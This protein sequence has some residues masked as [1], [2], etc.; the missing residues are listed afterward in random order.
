[1]TKYPRIAL[2]AVALAAGLAAARNS[3]YATSYTWLG[4]FDGNWNTT[5]GNVTNWGN[6]GNVLPAPAATTDLIFGADSFNTLNQNLFNPFDL[7]SITFISG[8]LAYTLNGSPL[9]FDV[10]GGSPPTI[11]EDA[12]T[13]QTI[14]ENLILTN[15]L[16]LKGGGTGTVSLNGILSSSGGLVLSSGKYTIAGASA[17][18]FT[19]PSTITGGTLTLSKAGSITGDFNINGG[20]TNINADAFGSNTTLTISNGS[21]VINPGASALTFGRF[22]LTGGSVTGTLGTYTLTGTA[23][24]ALDFGPGIGYTALVSLTGASGGGVRLGNSDSLGGTIN[25]GGIA[26]EVN[27]S[28]GT[29]TLSAALSNGSITTTGPG[30]LILSGGSKISPMVLGHLDAESGPVILDGSSGGAL[31]V[32][33]TGQ[34]GFVGQF[35]SI[36]SQNSSAPITIR[37][38]FTLHT[39]G[40]PAIHNDGSITIDGPATSWTNL[41]G[42]GKPA[43]S[44]EIRVGFFTGATGSTMSVQNGASV[45]SPMFRVGA[46]NQGFGQLNITGA[47]SNTVTGILTIADSRSSINVSGGGTLTAGMI[48]IESGTPTIKISDAPGEPAPLTVGN[49]TTWALGAPITDGPSGPGSLVKTANGSVILTSTSYTGSTT[50]N[51]GL[52]DVNSPTFASPLVVVGSGGTFVF[53]ATRYNPVFGQIRADGNSLVIYDNRAVINNAQLFGPGIHVSNY[54][55]ATFRN[56]TVLNG[57]ALTVSDTTTLSSVTVAGRLNNDAGISLVWDGGSLASSGNFDI[58]GNAQVSSFNS[59]GVINVHA[60]GLLNNSLSDLVLGGGSRTTV[61]PGSTPGTINLLSGTS[62]QLNGGLLVNDGKINGP[63][64]I[65]FGGLAEGAGSYQDVTITE[66]GKLLT[67][68][69]GNGPVTTVTSLAL[70]GSGTAD[71]GASSLIIDY[72]GLLL[73]QFAAGYIVAAYD[74]GRWDDPGITSASARTHFGTAVGYLDTATHPIAGLDSTSILIK[75]TWLGDANLDGVVNSADLAMID[76]NGT[77]W[78]QGDF[79]YD[80][81]VSADDYA[82]YNVG[83]AFSA[84][85]NIGTL[86]VPEP[87]AAFALFSL[88]PLATRR[89]LHRRCRRY[90]P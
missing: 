12:N 49:N 11:T 26:R 59:D 43:G 68:P 34:T 13:N 87:A 73:G 77:T 78:Q 56:V 10:D 32:T 70:Y 82:L 71:V 54:G 38:G 76:P 81:H 41:D 6:S 90:L 44:G 57:A 51:A 28:S 33:D 72:S 53:D 2:A 21:V 15:A 24:Y 17:N 39:A 19:G 79:N 75:F 74:K 80:G 46:A 61:F 85:A 58:S 22:V 89:P 50:V 16:N 20:T 27:V 66:G 67:G 64:V 47:G 86:S 69:R 45:Y 7:N 31:T 14:N 63:A 18:T 83:L 84:G 37:N 88:V 65:N 3:A 4:N 23:Q 36:F 25:L 60:Q 42:S 40:T 62:L 9:R 52:L 30:T 29:A 8:A 35:S 48:A 55:G 5:N 1:M